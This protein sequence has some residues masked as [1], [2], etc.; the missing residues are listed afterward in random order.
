MSSVYSAA[1][2]YYFYFLFCLI[3]PTLIAQVYILF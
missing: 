2:F 3:L 1:F